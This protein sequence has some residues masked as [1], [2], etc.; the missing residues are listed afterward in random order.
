MN[1]PDSAIAVAAIAPLLMLLFFLFRVLPWTRPGPW[2]LVLVL[3]SLAS[4]MFMFG[5]VALLAKSGID[6]LDPTHQLPLFL[7][8]LAAAAASVVAYFEGA[9]SA[10]RARLLALTDE[11]TG[12]RN[13]RAFEEYLKVAYESQRPFG[14]VY[15]D[16][17]GFKSV[18]DRLGHEA[19]D[20]A[21]QHVADVLRQAVREV[22]TAARLGGDEFALLL[23]SADAGGT[24]HVALRAL[25]GMRTLTTDHPEWSGL[26]ASFGVATQSDAPSAAALLHVADQ[27][28]YRAKRAGGGRVGLITS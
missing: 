12:L 13:R 3:V 10:E 4:V 27:A 11:L 19:G 26:N 1:G 9:R 6:G 28:M 16:L 25:A 8:V 17:D 24:E 21:L 18:N 22:D 2:R 5:E 7:A 15:I 14:L 20:K 23:P